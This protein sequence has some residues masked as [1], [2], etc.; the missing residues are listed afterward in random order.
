MPYALSIWARHDCIIANN[1]LHY[2]YFGQK[3]NLYGGLVF[4]VMLLAFFVVRAVCHEQEDQAKQR[5]AEYDRC[6]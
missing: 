3:V 1:S 6:L 4:A 2:R 5:P